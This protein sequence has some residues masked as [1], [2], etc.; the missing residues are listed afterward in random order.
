[1]SG[2]HNPGTQQSTRGTSNIPSTSFHRVHVP[3]APLSNA[4]QGFGTGER[5]HNN[6]LTVNARPPIRPPTENMHFTVQPQATPSQQHNAHQYHNIGWGAPAPLSG[7]GNSSG[8]SG[9]AA[10]TYGHWE[11]HQQAPSFS[12]PAPNQNTWG[13]HYNPSS[14]WYNSQPL[15]NDYPPGNTMAEAERKRT[16]TNLPPPPP[17]PPPPMQQHSA[18][19]NY[20]NTG[21]PHW[22]SL[23]QQSVVQK[24][25]T[26]ANVHG[27]NRPSLPNYGT[28]SAGQHSNEV[29]Y[30]GAP[31]VPQQSSFGHSQMYVPAPVQQHVSQQLAFQQIPTAAP[32]SIPKQQSTHI[33]QAPQQSHF[34]DA[35]P[36]PP[37]QVTTNHAEVPLQQQQ[38]PPEAS[39]RSKKRKKRK[40]QERTNHEEPGRVTVTEKPPSDS[41]NE[42]TNHENEEPVRVAVAEK[43]PSDANGG[44]LS[45]DGQFSD[46]VETELDQQLVVLEYLIQKYDIARPDASGVDPNLIRDLEISCEEIEELEKL[47]KHLAAT[48]EAEE[49]RVHLT[50]RAREI[51]ISS[52]ALD[53]NVISLVDDS[54]GVVV[55]DSRANN[56]WGYPFV[57][58]QLTQVP[59]DSQNTVIV[60]DNSAA[61]G[62]TGSSHNVMFA[63]ENDSKTTSEVSLPRRSASRALEEAKAKL[64]LA[65]LQ[66]SL[67]AK[68]KALQEAKAKSRQSVDQISA[69]LKGGLDCFMIEK[70][71]SSGS[72]SKI[73]FVDTVLIDDPRDDT[74]EKHSSDMSMDDDSSKEVPIRADDPSLDPVEEDL[75]LLCDEPS[76]QQRIAELQNIILTKLK[77]FESVTKLQR[78]DKMGLTS[79]LRDTVD[80]TMEEPNDTASLEATSSNGSLKE[81]KASTRALLKKRKEE[82]LRSRAVAHHKNVISKQQRMLRK[83]LIET[84]QIEQSIRVIDEEVL[85]LSNQK[86]PE[87]RVKIRTIE[88]RKQ[89][90][91]DML[92]GYLAELM[93]LRKELHASKQQ[94]QDSSNWT[95]SAN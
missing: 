3:P 84:E 70:I 52:R 25:P 31:F 14:I 9:I 13:V 64:R 51:I 47:G 79:L 30:Q 40:R 27:V 1:M 75:P 29:S 77:N 8:S 81:S 66:M 87:L 60:A 89:V 73:R 10:G 33:G 61:T 28:V 94:N 59:S 44:L 90:L 93:S 49:K 55:N 37:P 32:A 56:T 58:F 24:E 5:S 63:V 72:A 21:I 12:A 18:P 2:T 42:P 6:H 17:P 67:A 16:F 68:K 86:C 36:P 95:L 46:P 88:G 74:D 80:K 35:P 57:G 83:Q 43:T 92:G 4:Q 54:T 23:S 45:M 91:D 69:L 39:K 38:Q 50:R 78:L 26:N 41:R 85:M 82:A 11:P 76:L 62:S 65:K 53:T 22:L 48:T 34:H 15:T 71:S 20:S 19:A 7:T